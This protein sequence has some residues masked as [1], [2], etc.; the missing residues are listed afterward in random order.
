ML[1]RAEW[2]TGDGLRDLTGSG[3][4][5]LGSVGSV[6]SWC[7]M[8]ACIVLVCHTKVGG[9]EAASMPTLGRGGVGIGR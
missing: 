7:V 1:H 2:H 6:E 9:Y 5:G 4:E 3:L 8:C